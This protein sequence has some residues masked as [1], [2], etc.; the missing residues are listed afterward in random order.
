MHL[1]LNLALLE[2]MD[3]EPGITAFWVSAAVWGAI[4]YLLARRRWWWAVPILGLLGVSFAAVWSEWSDPFVGPAIS[5]EAGRLYPYHL[6]AS[7]VLAAGLTIAGLVRRIKQ[8]NE[9]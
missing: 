2:V 6:I 1:S 4:G 7:T 5:I 9:R 8:P 3:T